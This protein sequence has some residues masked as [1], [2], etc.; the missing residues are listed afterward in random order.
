MLNG[1]Y[2]DRIEKDRGERQSQT[3]PVDFAL[4]RHSQFLFPVIGHQNHD[5][6]RGQKFRLTIMHPP[7]RSFPA[8]PAYFITDFNHFIYV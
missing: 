1:I 7:P 3:A 5:H 2:T 6:H 4:S 8:P